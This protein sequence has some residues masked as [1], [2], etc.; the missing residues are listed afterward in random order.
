MILPL[1]YY[2]AFIGVIFPFLAMYYKQCGLNMKQIGVLTA[3]PGLVLIIVQQVWGYFADEVFGAKKLLKIATIFSCFFFLL[4][5]LTKNFYLLIFFVFLF[6]IFNGPWLHLL[7]SLILGQ[8]KGSEKY[9]IIRSFGSFTFV[10]TNILIGVITTHT[11]N[12]R[13]I[14]PSGIAVLI[15][16]F[17]SLR[18]IPELPGK[19]IKKASF[20]EI[21]KYFLSKPNVIL[22]LFMILFFQTAFSGGYLF[23]TFLIK[24]FNG[25][26]EDVARCY[27]FAAL[28]EI[29]MFMYLGRLAHKKGELFLIKI[30]II[31]QAIRWFCVYFSTSLIHIYI[32][33]IMH[34]MVFGFF[35]VGTIMYIN[36]IAGK[37]HRSSGQTLHGLV[38]SGI[39]VVLGNLLGGL[40][41]EIFK[42]KN[43]YLF[44]AILTIISFIFF[45]K[46][47][48]GEKKY[49]LQTK[50]A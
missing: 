5:G 34:P 15:I 50:D 3:L 43:L 12:L 41:V 20:I 48:K 47:L 21:Q 42:L 28:I 10:V 22:L 24:D 38:Y 36:K 13:I 26:N 25:T 46:L 44:G 16:S 8:P 32:L 35:Y 18:N 29:P 45:L 39:S 1:A 11:N 2:C 40:I 9:S 33:Q 31:A 14:F 30:A 19:K 4:V 49:G 23:Q 27:S 17:F 6:Y 37:E 7:N